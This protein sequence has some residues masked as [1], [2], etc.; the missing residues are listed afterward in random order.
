MVFFPEKT[1]ED[2]SYCNLMR[3]QLQLVHGSDIKD[4]KYYPKFM[5]VC[6]KLLLAQP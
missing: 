4:Y 1:P 6:L 3:E 2:L 5:G